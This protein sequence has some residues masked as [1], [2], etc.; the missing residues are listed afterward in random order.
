[1]ENELKKGKV[2]RWYTIGIVYIWCYGGLEWDGRIGDR[3]GIEKHLM[4]KV[5]RHDDEVGMREEERVGL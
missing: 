3:T 4:S 5:V 1:M 2:M